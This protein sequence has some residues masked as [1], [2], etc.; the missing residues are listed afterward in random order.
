MLYTKSAIIALSSLADLHK[1][2][3]MGIPSSTSPAQAFK[4]QIKSETPEFDKYRLYFGWV[5]ADTIKE[6]FEHTRQ[7]G[8][9]ITTFPMKRH[10]K[11]R[12]PALNVPRRH[13]AVAT[14]TVYSDTPAIDIG[15]IMAQLFCWE[16]VFGF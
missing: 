5:N 13:E 16:R 14:D 3:P 6:T 4:H 1:I 7:W 10:L 2:P 11:S 8:A 12:N 15:V 9:S